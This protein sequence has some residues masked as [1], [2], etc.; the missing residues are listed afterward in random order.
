M[1]DTPTIDQ[2]VLELQSLLTDLRAATAEAAAAQRSLAATANDARRAADSAQSSVKAASARLEA[3][4][5]KAVEAAMGG[6]AGDAVEALQEAAA[7]N[8]AMR[9]EIME[10]FSRM[11]ADWLQ[12]AESSLN[13]FNKEHV[14]VQRE[15][16]SLCDAQ[17]KAIG[18]GV[19]ACP[20]QLEIK[21]LSAETTKIAAQVLSASGRAALKRGKRA[22]R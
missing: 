16:E 1:T 13:S 18:S 8:R 21:R 19:H 15:I 2:K 11:Q 4:A 12:N 20:E 6:A 22:V 3:M 10:G 9:T 17:R 5:L 14:T 7:A